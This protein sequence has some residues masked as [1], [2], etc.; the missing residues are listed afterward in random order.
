MDLSVCVSDQF[1]KKGNGLVLVLVLMVLMVLGV[2]WKESMKKPNKRACQKDVGTFHSKA[3]MTFIRLFNNTSQD[4]IRWD[5]MRSMVVDKICGGRGQQS[6]SRGLAKRL[7]TLS[8]ALS[9]QK[10]RQTNKT[11]NTNKQH[12]QTTQTNKQTNNTNKQTTQTNNTNP[13]QINPN[14]PKSTQ[15]NPNQPKSTQINPN[16]INLNQYP[17]TFTIFTTNQINRNNYYYQSPHQSKPQSRN[18]MSTIM[19]RRKQKQQAQAA[20]KGEEGEL[21]A[22]GNSNHENNHHDHNS[23]HDNLNNKNNS[24][25]E[26][27]NNQDKDKDKKPKEKKEG[28]DKPFFVLTEFSTERERILSAFRT[29]DERVSC[30][31]WLCGDVIFNNIEQNINSFPHLPI[32]KHPGDCWRRLHFVSWLCLLTRCAHHGCYLWHGRSWVLPLSSYLR[33]GFWVFFFHAV[34]TSSISILIWTIID[35][36][37]LRLWTLLYLQHSQ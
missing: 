18:R 24:G 11:N 8:R 1:I 22:D 12:K 5:M 4:E 15:I 23:N 13:N 16:Q 37:G 19:K 10:L 7:C 30:V 34:F 36:S 33:F 2:V 9:Q 21:H 32:W 6:L 29:I 27:V 14:Q 17:S 31:S 35:W 20:A 26:E 3:A 28:D 25:N